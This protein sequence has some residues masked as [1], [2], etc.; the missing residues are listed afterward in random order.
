M[1]A[2]QATCPVCGKNGQPANL[3]SDTIFGWQQVF[4]RCPGCAALFDENPRPPK[5]ESNYY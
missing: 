3:V 5:Y 1:N 4:L 2:N